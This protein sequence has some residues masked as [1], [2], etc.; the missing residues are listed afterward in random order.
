MVGFKI[1]AQLLET[2]FCVRAAV[3]D[4]LEFDRV[5][6]LPPVSRYHSQLTSVVVLDTTEPGVYDNAVQDVEY[7]IHVAS[8]LAGITGVCPRSSVFQFA[9]RGSVGL[10]ESAINASRI[11]RI[12]IT[13][14]ILSIASISHLIDGKVIN[15]KRRQSIAT[16]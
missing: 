11:R 8:P 2:G 6:S 12:V 14:S 3:R 5:S 7:I 4:K 15:G 13:A 9:V 16:H 10:L 1:M